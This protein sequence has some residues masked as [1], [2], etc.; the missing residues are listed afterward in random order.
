[1][2]LFI[3]FRKRLLMRFLFIIVGFVCALNAEN[4][5]KI[6]LNQ[7]LE[8]VGVELEKQLANKKFW[9]NEL[10]DKNLS[11]GYYD[12]NAAIV[13]TN[14]TNKTFKVF[15][16]ENG[17]LTQKFDQK[18]GVTGLMGDKE[19]QGDLKTPVGFY[20][21]G[22]KF[23]PEDQY[24]GGLAF[25][26]SY[27]NLLDKVQG[28]TGGGI[29]I[30]GY[31]LD[32]ERLDELKT[33]GCIALYNDVL[34]DFSKVI[35][36]Q[37]ETFA[38]TEEKEIV[39]TNSNEIAILFASLFAWKDKWT[40]NDIKSYL[41]FYDEKDFK[42]FDKKNFKE[43]AAMKEAIF[44]RKEKKVIK[45]SKINISPYPNIKNEKMFRITFYQDYYTPNHQF[46]GNKTLYVKLD[47][48]NK[49]KILVEK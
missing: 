33:R 35:E 14:K 25:A 42:R 6:Y 47:D 4:L 48:E 30:H 43:F 32:G 45:F 3:L 17:K 20:E 24:Y 26:T 13:V 7:G 34:K 39:R 16:Y 21:L 19:V 22:A 10:N 41:E 15:F 9:L 38:M 12:E 40:R 2:S 31:P 49:M 44:S 5:A 1:M 28:K 18:V 37:K 46:K 36:R 29:W 27:P 11:L 8:A 23:R